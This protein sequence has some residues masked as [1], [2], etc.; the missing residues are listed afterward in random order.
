M[1]SYTYLSPFQAVYKTQRQPEQL[2]VTVAHHVCLFTN[3]MSMHDGQ[4]PGKGHE[5]N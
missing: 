1:M 4:P 5:N 2:V 3:S